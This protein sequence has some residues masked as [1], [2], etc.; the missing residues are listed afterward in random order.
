MTLTRQW[1]LTLISLKAELHPTVILQAF[2]LILN[3][4]S[5]VTGLQSTSGHYKLQLWQN[6]IVMKSFL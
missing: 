3:L 2:L 1:S 6:H 5:T 4:L